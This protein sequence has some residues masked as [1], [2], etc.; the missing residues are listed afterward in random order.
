MFFNLNQI[1]MRVFEF[2]YMVD[3]TDYIFL[4]IY[5]ICLFSKLPWDVYCESADNKQNY[6]ELS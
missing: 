6:I 5:F 1:V 3:W 4:Y 2:I